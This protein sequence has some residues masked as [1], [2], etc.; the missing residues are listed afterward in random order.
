VQIEVAPPRRMQTVD[1]RII[2]HVGPV[3][4]LRAEPEIVDVGSRT[5]LEDAD[6]LVL[7]AIKAPLARVGFVPNQEVLPL[8]IEGPGG[9]QQ[10]G[11]MPPMNK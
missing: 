6:Q 5:V 8:G 1:P 4:A 2:E 3:S 9:S 7:R 11:E 10:F